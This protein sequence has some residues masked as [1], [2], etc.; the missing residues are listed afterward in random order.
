MVGE[1]HRSNSALPNRF[2][3]EGRS[4]VGGGS[5]LPGIAPG[6]PLSVIINASGKDAVL[7]GSVFS[8]SVTIANQGSRSALIEVW[9][10]D[11]TL[12]LQQ[13]S[14]S[15][16]ERLALGPDQS[17][18][19][20]LRLQIPPT[21]PPRTY[22]YQVVVDAQEDYPEDTPI[23]FAQQVQV[24]PARQATTSTHDATLLL[25]PATTP[26]DPVVVQAGGALPVQVWVHNRSDRVDRFHL[27]CPDLP[28]SWYSITYPQSLGGGAG[29]GSVGG[30]GGSGLVVAANCLN[31]NPN[32]QGLI[33]V[34]FKPPIEALAD[35]YS[36]T[37]RLHS[38]N[39]PDLVLLDWVYWQVP[40]AYQ[41][42]AELRTLIGRVRRQPGHYQIRFKNAGNTR[43]HLDLRS[44]PLDE[45]KLCTYTLD[46][47][48][49]QILP[50]ST[51]Q[52]DLQVQPNPSWRRPIWG[53]GRMLNF[54][55]ELKD[56]HNLPLSI[57]HLPGYLLWESRPWWQLL[58]ILLLGL[59]GLGALAY[60]LWWSLL[61]I[62]PAPK[63]Q[64]FAAE[65]LTYEALQQDTVRLGWKISQPQRLQ[66][67]TIKG[68]AA[69][70]GGALTQPDVY[71]FSQGIPPSLQGVCQLDAMFLTCRNVRTSAQRPAT[72][73]F[74]LVMQSKPGRGEVSE[75]V[76]TSPVA[77]AP[78]P[79]P[80]ILSFA[81]TRPQY[82]EA[83]A[84]AP[85][86]AEPVGEI[87]LN[88]AIAN[89]EQ[90]QTVA[91]I[92]RSPD[93]AVRSP[94]QQF[95]LTQGLPAALQSACQWQPAQPLICRNVETKAT[96]AGD[97]VFELTAV[98]KP[99]TGAK[100][101]VQKT[102]LI[103]ILPKPLRILE[104]R[105]NGQPAQ[106]HYIFP[107]GPDQ[108]PPA[109]QLSW[110]V[111]GSAGTQVQLLPAPGTVPLAA[112]VPLLL[113]AKPN[114]VTVTLQVS[115]PDGQQISRS[116][117]LETL[118]TTDPSAATAAAVAKAIAESQQADPPAASAGAS[119]TGPAS[120]PALTVPRPIEP[121]QIAPI[122]LP[123]QFDRR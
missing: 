120:P 96:G 80:K 78:I 68:L 47:A 9:I 54:E 107:I 52:V 35:T 59:L 42:T 36:P 16:K 74:E 119:P 13:W 84:L 62:P 101:E 51:A 111:E 65:D 30:P 6:R 32:E 19:V 122:E 28:R 40:P 108:L 31:L 116:L 86:P 73:V 27:V 88:W 50:H 89:P 103:K 25:Q 4:P 113:A 94:L 66:S 45:D 55:I 92:G 15:G 64:Q 123:P 5:G 72:Y 118:D 87:R 44:L 104:F 53:G 41:L 69:A 61:R 93:G 82:Q 23:Q 21:A 105:L 10:D 18:E 90:L 85:K 49:L 39:H 63:I 95:D 79:A 100:P 22:P 58:P 2:P 33:S 8:I 97:Y 38:D 57:D 114:S 17:A 34:V 76:K 60:L 102:E 24:L 110:F 99:V 11:R 98:P 29:G 106:P 26:A 1:S 117:T 115:S 3:L 121:T 20:V 71:D 14:L 46:R 91:L 43:R 77:I 112:N 81:A 56:G 7:P 70:G 37:L 75:T 67:L 12:L 48:A 109:L 83:S